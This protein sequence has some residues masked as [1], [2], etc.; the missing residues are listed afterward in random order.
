MNYQLVFRSQ[1]GQVT[2][3]VMAVISVVFMALIWR[4]DGFLP[5]LE[6][7]PLPIGLAYFSWWIWGWPAVVVDSRGVLIRNQ[8]RTYRIGWSSF[9][10]AE[11]RFGLYIYV[12]R[13]EGEGE[14]GTRLRE[15][16]PFGSRSATPSPA[17]PS[18]TTPSPAGPSANTD[19]SRPPASSSAQRRGRPDGPNVRAEPTIGEVD[20]INLD[21]DGLATRKPIYA[22]GVPARGGFKTATSKEMP[23]VP[24]LDLRIRNRVV[25]H[26]TPMVAARILDEEKYYLDNPTE[27]PEL[28]SSTE[29]YN[30]GGIGEEPNY[31]GVRTSINWLQISGLVAFVAYWAWLL[32]PS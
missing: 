15:S 2:A 29:G 14:G 9:V 5:M 22:A 19:S 3:V 24:T 16:S 13:D 32:L 27:R 28:H 6:S 7:A 4:A 1:F 17:T 20:P 18:P 11:S 30:K 12:N 31:R 21:P 23:Q 10:K 26:V 8:L 25:L